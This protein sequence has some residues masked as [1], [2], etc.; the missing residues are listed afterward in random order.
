ML[1]DITHGGGWHIGAL[2]APGIP[3]MLL[4]GR[5][6][7]LIAE[8]AIPSL[9]ATPGAFTGAFTG[10]DIDELT[11]PGGSRMPSFPS[12]TR[13]T[14]RNSAGLRVPCPWG[15]RSAHE[16][17]PAAGLQFRQRPAPWPAAPAERNLT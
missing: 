14:V 15:G 12:T 7:A 3:E 16:P 9:C 4:A 11:R 5:E 2:V 10:E 8:H 17:G 13:P 1:A 6:R